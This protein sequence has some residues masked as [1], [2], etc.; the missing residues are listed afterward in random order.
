MFTEQD[1][2]VCLTT[3][4]L[5]LFSSLLYILDQSGQ[6]LISF[7]PFLNRNGF[8]LVPEQQQQQTK[9]RDKTSL[10]AAG[11]SCWAHQTTMSLFRSLVKLFLIEKDLC[12]LCVV[13]VI[14]IS[15][16]KIEFYAILVHCMATYLVSPVENVAR[17]GQWMLTSLLSLMGPKLGPEQWKYT[18]SILIVS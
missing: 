13:S 10:Q 4:F 1:W 16:E 17:I 3:V 12:K 9:P 8:E 5:P 6:G 11:Q 2:R 15:V 18:T 14:F 7:K